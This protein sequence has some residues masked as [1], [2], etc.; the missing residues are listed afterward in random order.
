MRHP[1]SAIPKDNDTT[2]WF[3]TE[4]VLDDVTC[5]F[6]LWSWD[7]L[8]GKSFIFDIACYEKFGQEG[9]LQQLCAFDDK[10]STPST[11]KPSGDGLF[12]FFNYM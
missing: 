2:V 3:Q 12:F 8:R 4:I 11:C 7:G 9:L 1:I 10:C 6:Q 5:Y